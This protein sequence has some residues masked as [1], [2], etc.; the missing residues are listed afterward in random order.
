MGNDKSSA[1]NS[2]SVVSA[3]V[4]FKAV[5][6]GGTMWAGK[7]SLYSISAPQPISMA[8]GFPSVL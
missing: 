1:V 7:T 3:V 4:W 6:Q 2:G 5:P 8:N